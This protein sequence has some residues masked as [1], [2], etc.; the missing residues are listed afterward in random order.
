MDPKAID[1]EFIIG[2]M[3]LC[4]V[5]L[6]AISRLGCGLFTDTRGRLWIAHR[7]AIYGAVLCEST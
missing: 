7:H 6:G 3:A 1:T 5:A 2:F 4:V